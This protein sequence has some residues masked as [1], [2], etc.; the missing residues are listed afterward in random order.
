MSLSDEE[1]YTGLTPD[2]AES[3]PRQARERWGEERVTEVEDKVRKLSKEQWARIGQQG[4]DATQAMAALIGRPADDNEVQA[5]ISQHHVWIEN[6]YP[7]PAEVYRG[8]GTM[9]VEHPEFRKFYEDHAE[10]LAGFMRA[11]IEVYCERNLS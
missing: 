5:A 4:E 9:Y 3:Y 1:L 10:G 8:L 2:Q 11:A 7:A 6:F